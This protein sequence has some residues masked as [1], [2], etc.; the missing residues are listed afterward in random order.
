[1]VPPLTCNTGKL[2]IYSCYGK[3][4]RKRKDQAPY[5][6]P[7]EF[8]SCDTPIYSDNLLWLFRIGELC[9]RAFLLKWCVDGDDAGFWR[10]GDRR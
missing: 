5:L 6:L 9:V 10:E 8:T 1:M 4:Y 7:A 3:S 2:H